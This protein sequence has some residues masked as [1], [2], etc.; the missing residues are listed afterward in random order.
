MLT[1][2]TCLWNPNRHSRSFSRMYDESWADK[3]YRGFK[4]NLTVPFRFVV[5]ADFPRVFGERAIEQ[6]RI[7]M[8]DP[9]YGA[10]IEPFRLDEPCLVVGLDTIVVGNCD[11]LAEY[12]LTATKA[13]VPRDPYAGVSR[14]AR[15]NAVVA[16]PKGAAKVIWDGYVGQN[17]MDYIN[18]C[19]TDLLDDHFPRQVVSY[20]G[21]IQQCGLEDETRIVF[22]HGPQKPHELSHVGWIGRCWHDNVKQEIAA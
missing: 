13:A 1:V 2:A 6:E 12:C 10:M 4:L 18:T 8:L 15:S 17:D 3:L 16:C 5:F 22:F 9:H 21:R 19:D 20:K 7:K 14:W 11:A